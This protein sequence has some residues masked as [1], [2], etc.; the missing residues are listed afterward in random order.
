MGSGG[1]T[2]LWSSS[3]LVSLA[4]VL[5]YCN[6]S[7]KKLDTLVLLLDSLTNRRCLVIT[8]T[9]VQLSCTKFGCYMVKSHGQLVSV[10]ST[11]HN[12]YTPD[13]STWWSS[14]ALQGAQGSSEISS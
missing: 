12:A 1:S 11:P 9:L 7:R 2:A 10:S 4:V 3:K 8:F 5:H 14:R 13:L 6:R